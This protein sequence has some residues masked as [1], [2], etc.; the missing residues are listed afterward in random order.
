MQFRRNLPGAGSTDFYLTDPENGGLSIEQ[1]EF[2]ADLIM[3]YRR[4]YP[5]LKINA[6]WDFGM[7]EADP[8]QSE[9]YGVFADNRDNAVYNA[10]MLTVSINH[11]KV[12]NMSCETDPEQ[13]SE[14]EAYYAGLSDLAKRYAARQKELIA[15]GIPWPK[16]EG[17]IRE[18]MQIVPCAENMLS[19]G[20]LYFADVQAIRMLE[21]TES[22]KRLLIHEIGHMLSE[23]TGAVAHKKIRKLF[24]KCRDGFENIYEFC[25]ECFMA[26]ELTDRIKLA[27]EYRETL[28][29][30]M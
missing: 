11:A 16:I 6:V 12:R 4:K 9:K 29:S 13:I 22:L 30:V 14:I 23:E 28:M 21:N 3:A 26:S 25:A 24:G 18:E 7:E 27:N 20:D 10:K 17:I 15:Q 1:Q 5:D 2:A 8:V 19:A